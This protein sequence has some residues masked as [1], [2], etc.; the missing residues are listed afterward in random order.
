MHAYLNTATKVVRTISKVLVRGFDDLETNPQKLDEQVQRL[1]EKLESKIYTDLLKTYP[2]HEFAFPGL[3][4]KNHASIVWHINVLS[5]EENFRRGIPHFAIVMTICEKNKPQHALIFNPMLQELFTATKGN[6]V[7]LNNKRLRVTTI[8]ELDEALVAA[9]F[10]FARPQLYR[11]G[12]PALDLAYVA[13]GRFDG[14]VGK[15]VNNNDMTAGTLMVKVAGGLFGDWQ[16][17]TKQEET[18]ELIAANAKLFKELL[19]AT[20]GSAS[21]SS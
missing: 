20:N 4:I 16:G 18:G 12:C 10:N 11:T 17:D 19:R 3:V 9:N 2:D 5:G 14:F 7:Q 6:Q 8:K 15:D 1:R 13:A 21:I